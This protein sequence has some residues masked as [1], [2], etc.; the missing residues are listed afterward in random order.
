VL[1]I[2]L[3]ETDG[4]IGKWIPLGYYLFNSPIKKFIEM[5]YLQ[6]RTWWSSLK[7]DEAGPYFNV[8]F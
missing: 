3:H 1:G 8:P 7:I 5:N 6:R 2:Q 4:F